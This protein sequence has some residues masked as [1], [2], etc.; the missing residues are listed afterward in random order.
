VQRKFLQNQDV[1]ILKSCK[2]DL[3][4]QS[5]LLQLEIGFY[6]H[7]MCC[8]MLTIYISLRLKDAKR[9]HDITQLRMDHLILFWQLGKDYCISLFQ[10]ACTKQDP[11]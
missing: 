2:L 7:F 8:V 1:N 4:H 3:L 11:H 9:A 10:H 5:Y 6:H